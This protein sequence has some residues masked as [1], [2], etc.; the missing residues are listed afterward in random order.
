MPCQ[1]YSTN[2]NVVVVL[3]VMRYASASVVLRKV[4]NNRA[5]E[6]GQFRS[7]FR[8]SKSKSGVKVQLIAVVIVVPKPSQAKREG[9]METQRNRDQNG[10]KNKRKCFAFVRRFLLCGLSLRFDACVWMRLV[11]VRVRG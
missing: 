4:K 9:R 11:L 1:C 2:G 10:T 5:V 3:C 6:V 8:T 7:N